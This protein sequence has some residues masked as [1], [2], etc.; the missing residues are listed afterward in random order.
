MDR[1]WVVL[2]ALC[3]CALEPRSHEP[4][5]EQAITNGSAD[6]GD[7]AVVALV[8]TMDQVGCTAAVIGPHTAITAAH[9]F[10]GPKPRTLRIFAGSTLADSVATP[11]SNVRLH[12]AFDPATLAHDLAMVTFRDELPV[13]PLAL[14][15]RPIDATLVG[16][17]VRIV[18][19]GTTSGS[20]ADG[21]SKREGTARI[22]SVD[23]EEL[24]AMANP[25]QPCRGDSGGPA[26]LADDA[27]AAVVSRGDA[28][29]ADHATYAR[30]DVARAVLVDPYLA[31]TAPATAHTGDACFFAGHCAEGPCLVTSDDPLLWFCSQ[32]C[33]RDADCPAAM[34]CA[35]DGCR[36]P[37][38]S[39]GALGAACER[40]DE[41]TSALC[42]NAVCTI[43]CLANPDACPAHFECRRTGALQFC[44]ATPDDA[45]CAGCSSGSQAPVWLVLIYFVRGRRTGRSSSRDGSR[46]ARSDRAPENRA[47]S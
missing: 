18:G 33:A 36:Y 34:V 41:C 14:E 27:I 24:V 8:D 38:P 4:A 47:G 37:E 5:S 28:A 2:C 23:A 43:S 25:S 17:D 9:C 7:P 22:T 44:Y 31:S 20:G 40:D 46:V 13:T 6:L 1:W 19:F 30:I 26:L 39:P 35:R 42:R 11:V 3:A 12:P 29:C 45:S 15:P 16:T 21:G 32:A 10:L